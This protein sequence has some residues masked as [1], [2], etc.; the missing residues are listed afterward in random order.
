[1]SYRRQPTCPDRSL[2]FV[3]RAF[4]R[5]FLVLFALLP[6]ITA[7]TSW[8]IPVTPPAD[9]DPTDDQPPELRSLP[10]VERGEPRPRSPSTSAQG[11]AEA[12]LVRADHAAWR[13][14]GET[15][16][17]LYGQALALVPE[18]PVALFGLGNLAA[19]EER[20]GEAIEWFRRTTHADPDHRDAHFNLGVALVRQDRLDEA[21]PPFR[22]VLALAP[23]DHQARHLLAELHLH[24]SEATDDPK[25]TLEEL[26]AAAT[27][28]P[29]APELWI[30]VAAQ[31]AQLGRLD[32]AIE[33]YDL[34]LARAPESTEA[35]LGRATA[36]LLGHRFVAARQALEESLRTLADTASDEVRRGLRHSLARLL[37]SGPETSVRDGARALDLALQVFQADPSTTHG[38]TV[39]MAYAE[40]GRFD[41]AQHWQQ[42]MVDALNESQDGGEA[43]GEAR[44]RLDLYR[45]EKPYRSP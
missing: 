23:D 10:S 34:A 32:D 19:G 37:A 40:I 24:R 18:H 7:A 15:A 6:A 8:A 11:R 4:G 2:G 20:L 12:I 28:R 39:A 27:L 30:A 14:D 3:G 29:E 9:P 42:R 43:L 44:R 36:L 41:L 17:E 13:G 35:H 21:L 31:L 38:E 16:R 26:R 45:D 25:E 22:R 33:N 5:R 1:M